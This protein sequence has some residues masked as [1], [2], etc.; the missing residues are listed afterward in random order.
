MATALELQHFAVLTVAYFH[1][2]ASIIIT[3]TTNNPC[4]L[5]LYYTDKAPVRHTTSLVKRGVALPWGAYFCF[6]AWNSVEQQE[7]GDTLTHTFEVP[8]WS[9]C[10]TKWFAFRG[11]V[12][13]ILS[14]SVS[15]L[16]KH[17]HPG[18][19]THETTLQ[20][21][22]NN[23]DYRRL[24]GTYQACPS[25]CP[26]I[27]EAGYFYAIRRHV[28]CGLRFLYVNIPQ[29][30]TI[31][32]AN[33]IFTASQD[34]AGTCRYTRISAEQQDNPPD[35]SLDDW[36]SARARWQNSGSAID[37]DNIPAWTQDFEY[38]SPDISVVIQELVDRPLWELGNSQVLFFNDWDERAGNLPY[39]TR[40]AYSHNINPGKAVKL[41]IKW[42]A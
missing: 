23:D 19:S 11:T 28:G 5:T 33:L 10:Q 17:H 6:V 22:H 13:G 18:V 14:P 35:F 30:A 25:V 12:A 32:E 24:D 29:Y 40:R 2:T 27:L 37:W 38:T 21:A 9:Y 34:K 36:L 20:I 16:I 15:A 41:Y 8:D 26:P 7:A 31:L 42:D 4:H 1:K 39:V 3:C